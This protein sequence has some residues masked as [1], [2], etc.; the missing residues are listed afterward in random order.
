[1][2]NKTDQK[3][4]QF[5]CIKCGACCSDEIIKITLTHIDLLRLFTDTQD[6]EKIKKLLSVYILP[7]DNV[8]EKQIKN[9][10]MEKMVISP[11][12][13]HEGEGFI[14]LK[15]K[16]DNKSC[17]FLK[18]NQEC[19]IYQIRPLACR[20]FPF[21]YSFEKSNNPMIFTKRAL[22][23][24]PGI[25]K[26]KIIDI[27]KLKENGENVLKELANF[28]YFTKTLNEYQKQN[29]I[30]TLSEIISF[31]ILFAEKEFSQSEG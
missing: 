9:E 6:I 19:S 10:I 14:C 30:M 31:A 2:I 21:F 16:D 15:K 5:S 22:E 1:M 3:I 11:I 27:N 8:S 23:I 12:I 18:N 25:G 29:E 4:M 17:I 20:T 13:M 7:K 28:S 24:C 26:G